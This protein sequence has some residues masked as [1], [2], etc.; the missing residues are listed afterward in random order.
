MIHH[1]PAAGA[2]LELSQVRGNRVS[3]A[4]A[5]QTVADHDANRAHHLPLWRL[6]VQH[7]R[8]LHWPWKDWVG[9]EGGSTTHTTGRSDD[10]LFLF[11]S[12]A[13][14]DFANDSPS[15]RQLELWQAVRD[16]NTS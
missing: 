9:V 12:A 16:S 7:L 10:L 13:G 2:Y 6:D 15:I 8:S 3:P 14:E 4:K 11:L 5:A 1:V